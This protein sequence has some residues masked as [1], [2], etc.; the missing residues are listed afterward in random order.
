MSTIK[1]FR[2]TPVDANSEKE[3]FE[4]AERCNIL[5]DSGLE[6]EE[7]SGERLKRLDAYI[8]DLKDMQIRDGLHVLAKLQRENC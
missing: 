2:L 7:L 8:C 6:E 3:I 4:T 1:L 5:K